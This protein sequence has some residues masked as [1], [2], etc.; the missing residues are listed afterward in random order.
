MKRK[1]KILLTIAVMAVAAL[2]WFA[3][4]FYVHYMNTIVRSSVK[5]PV[6]FALQEIS[7]DMNNGQ[8]DTAKEKLDILMRDWNDYFLYNGVAGH[9]FSGILREFYDVTQRKKQG[10]G[11]EM[12]K[13]P[14]SKDMLFNDWHHA[15]DFK[16]ASAERYVSNSQKMIAEI[17][18]DDLDE[19]GLF[20]LSLYT[21]DG[22]NRKV[23]G[24]SCRGISVQWFATQCGD[25]LAI[26]NDVDT[27]YNQSFVVLPHVSKDD[28]IIINILYMDPLYFSS[29]GEPPPGHIY[30]SIKDIDFH[31]T[32]LITLE[33]D[34]TGK[35]SKK[36]LCEIPVFLG[37]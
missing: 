34:F 18:H 8:Y 2:G 13:P 24:K 12:A 22:K 23:I 25:V 35:G 21:G 17:S 1:R 10:G 11:Q 7:D 4:S 30:S 32:M 15:A 29:C 5:A 37:F 33:W 36:V 31:G 9:A 19:S 16:P 26:K 27:H 20:L 28:E 3:V 14:A 6:R